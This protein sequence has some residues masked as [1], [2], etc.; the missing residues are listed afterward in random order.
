MDNNEL[1]IWRALNELPEVK[2]VFGEWDF[3]DRYVSKGDGGILCEVWNPE[4]MSD[5]DFVPPL[6][7]SIR[8][9]RSLIGIMFSQ[10]EADA[11]KKN[12]SS[13][14][15][16]LTMHAL[17]TLGLRRAITADRPDLAIARAIIEMEGK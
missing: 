11:I 17:K 5:E 13:E 6:Y 1:E 16:E 9:E 3:G 14:I 8:P 15:T 10:I 7:D 12:G 4:R 2:K